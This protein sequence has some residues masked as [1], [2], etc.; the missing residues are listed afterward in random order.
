MREAHRIAQSVGDSQD[1]IGASK[2]ASI[3]SLPYPSLGS[4]FKG[5]DE[6][7]EGLHAS[8]SRGSGRNAIVG[9]AVYGLGGIGKP[10]PQ[11]NMR[12]RT[13][14]TIRAGVLIADTPKRCGRPTLRRSSGRGAEPAEQHA[15]EE[16]VRL[17][18]CRLLAASGG[19][20][21]LDSLDM[22][23]ALESG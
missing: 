11:S 20:S 5:R 16:G 23:E 7:S 19:G 18:R 8:L 2:P 15:A 6:F 22:P 10:G 9:S 14:T 1:G 3:I 17:K 21:H 4:L 12:G 13:R